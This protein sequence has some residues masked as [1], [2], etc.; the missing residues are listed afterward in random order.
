[1]PLVSCVLNGHT[2]AGIIKK[3]CI[4]YGFDRIDRRQSK[5]V[6][7]ISFVIPRGDIILSY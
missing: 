1:M 2:V 3:K 7:I 6:P 4:V 5:Q